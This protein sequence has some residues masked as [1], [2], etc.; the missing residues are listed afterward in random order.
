MNLEAEEKRLKHIKQHVAKL[1]AEHD[2]RQDFDFGTRG[3]EFIRISEIV[4]RWTLYLLSW[5]KK[6]RTISLYRPLALNHD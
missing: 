3:G 6:G 5:L 4:I 2:S 1:K